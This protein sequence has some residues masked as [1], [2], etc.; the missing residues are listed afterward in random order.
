MS[1]LSV[2]VTVDQ[3]LRLMHCYLSMQYIIKEF[4]NEFGRVDVI[5]SHGDEYFKLRVPR[6]D[7]TVGFIFSILESLN[8]IK[9]QG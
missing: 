9:L 4:L 8:S 7:K 5:E 3:F 1:I 2:R 6:Q